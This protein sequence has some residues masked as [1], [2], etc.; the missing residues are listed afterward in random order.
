MSPDRGGVFDTLV[1]LVRL[2]LGGRAA[3]G[4]QYVSWIHD[5]DFVRAVS[6]LIDHEETAGAVNLAAPNPLPN[7]EFMSAI[8]AAWGI[9]V[10]LP[11]ARWMLEIGALAMRTET[12]LLLKSR[13]V[14]PG[15]LAAAG[16]DFGFPDWRAA[17]TDLR[18][19]YRARKRH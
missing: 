17:V 11:A 10:G 2:G 16:F 3:S 7:A 14:V 13:R 9:P 8:R 18:R 12:E 5:A 1:S 6:W 19:R 15:R 4:R